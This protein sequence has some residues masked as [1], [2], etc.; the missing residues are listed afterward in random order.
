MEKIRVYKVY[1]GLAIFFLVFGAVITLMGIALI[2]KSLISGFN[3]AFPGGDWN[4]VFFTLQGMLFIVMGS[5]SLLSRKYFIEW[6]EQQLRYLLPD[7]KTVQI[8]KF[9]D[10]KSVNIR[11]FE[12]ELTL[13]DSAKSLNLENLQF[14]DIKKVKK[15]FEDTGL[16]HK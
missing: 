6:D 8:I 10:I 14:E 1:K 7:K 12:I 2:I 16:L 5:A 15:K 9:T 3:I 4:A 11:L 13:P